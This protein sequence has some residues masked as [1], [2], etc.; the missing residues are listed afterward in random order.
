[1]EDLFELSHGRNIFFDVAVNMVE[2]LP[3]QSVAFLEG[4]GCAADVGSDEASLCAKFADDGRGKFEG[5]A[6]GLHDLLVDPLQIA[7]NLEHPQQLLA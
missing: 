2:F 7:H 1:L 5:L 3:S 6:V 4:S